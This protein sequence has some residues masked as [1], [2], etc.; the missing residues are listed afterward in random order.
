VMCDGSVAD[1]AYD[2]AV[3]VHRSAACRE[4]GN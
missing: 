1:V 3:A 2:V 4:D